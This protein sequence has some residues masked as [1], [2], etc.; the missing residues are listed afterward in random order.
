MLFEKR[1]EKLIREINQNFF[2]FICSTMPL[3]FKRFEMRTH[4]IIY[5]KEIRWSWL[6]KTYNLQNQLW[7][8]CKIKVIFLCSFFRNTQRYLLYSPPWFYSL[9]YCVVF[10]KL[11]CTSGNKYDFAWLRMMFSSPIFIY[12]IL[13]NCVC[14]MAFMEWAN[15]M[16]HKA[17]STLFLPQTHIWLEI[18]IKTYYLKWCCNCSMRLWGRILHFV[19]LL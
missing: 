19:C 5:C 12:L 16:A 13:R 14:Q 15:M 8:N 10:L 2:L 4:L 18:P 6:G 1:F 11:Y 3:K 17:S 7:E 9:L